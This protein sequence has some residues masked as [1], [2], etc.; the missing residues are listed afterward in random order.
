MHPRNFLPRFFLTAVLLAFFFAF[1]AA[2][3]LHAQDPEVLKGTIKS[4]D[5]GVIILKDVNFKDE[6]L[7]RKDV[8]VLWDKETAFYYGGTR[9]P[10]EE[11]VPGYLVLVKCAQAGSERKALSVR[12]IKGK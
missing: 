3:P 10:K 9:V 8:K 11:V 5:P 12:V 4:L 1:G 2:A 6:S 7:Q